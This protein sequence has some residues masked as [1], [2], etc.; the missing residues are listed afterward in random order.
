[1]L[2]VRYL[3]GLAES[4]V[5]ADLLHRVTHEWDCPATRTAVRRCLDQGLVPP[6]AM[7]LYMTMVIRF[8]TRTVAEL[9]PLLPSVGAV[10]L[11]F[12]DL[13]DADGRITGPLRDIGAALE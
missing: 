1:G 4:G 11:K 3:H 12:W 9:D 8:G 10:H 2:P 7:P 6:A 5:P 13:D